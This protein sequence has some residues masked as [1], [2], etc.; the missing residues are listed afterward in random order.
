MKKFKIALITVCAV[1]SALL[2]VA[3]AKIYTVTFDP[4][5]GSIL[6]G[7]NIQTINEGE[8]ATPPVPE[9]RGYVFDGWEGN[10]TAVTGDESLRAKWTPLYT[11]TF[12]PCGGTAADPSL[13]I[14][15]IPQSKDAVVPE[16]SRE[17]Y[18]FDGWSNENLT[19]I[20]TDM[21]VTAKWTRVWSVRYFLTGGEVSNDRLLSQT[22]RDDQTPTD[23]KPKR[24]KYT[25]VEWTESV[26]EAK[27]TKYYT[28]V[29]QRNKYT[30][31]EISKMA[32]AATAEVTTYRPGGREIALGSGFF[33]NDSGLLV[34]NYHVIK[35][36]YTIKAKVGK[37]TYTAKWIVN[38][39]ETLDVAIIQFE[40]GN[41][42]VGYFELEDKQPSVGDTVYAVGSSL[43]LTGTFSSGIVS[44]VGREIDGVKFIQ[45]TAPISSGNSGG[46]LINEYG[47]V[48]GMN[49]ATYVEGQNLNLAI[50][51][52]DILSV[53]KYQNYYTLSDW[54]YDTTDVK[55]LPGDVVK[56][57]SEP[58]TICENGTT[59]Q[60]TLSS[61]NSEMFI[62]Q[63]KSAEQVLMVIIKLGKAEDLDRLKGT[64]V[65]SSLKNGVMSYPSSQ[66]GIETATAS[67]V[68]EEGNAWLVCIID[69]P[70]AKFN[71]GY[72]WYGLNLHNTTPDISFE[73]FS[74]MIYP[75]EAEDIMDAL[76]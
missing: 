37:T 54:F 66:I 4:N 69:I 52:K 72:T 33:I 44:Y 56:K 58:Y 19:D 12:D 60:G 75:D 23:P 3:C 63:A 41:R 35:G 67:M 24:D 55:Y 9:R 32:N 46:P 18:E 49:T 6:S 8:N 64:V 39:N 68:D 51:A 71:Q 36:A 59:Y 14:Q 70:D 16:V 28:A 31:S 38:A 17:G 25:F 13:L 57:V 62:T 10:Y 15:T 45:T 29:W 34:T 1:A 50:S 61:R 73:Y 53:K 27:N 48:I 26:D 76:E 42:T 43:G 47:E 20:K 21:T 11:V 2:L 40:M 22:I 65:A 30:A 5:G 74:W 7:E